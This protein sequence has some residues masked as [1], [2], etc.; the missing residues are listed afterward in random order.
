MYNVLFAVR[1]FSWQTP[2]SVP[3]QA[4]ILCIDPARVF[5][6]LSSF[7]ACGMYACMRFLVDADSF[8]REARDMLIR[9]AQRWNIPV[10]LVADRA[11]VPPGAVVDG[12][13]M[14]V[15]Q[16]GQ[17]SADKRIAEMATPDD[18]VFTRDIVF[19]EQ[20]INKKILAMNDRGSIFDSS[21]IRERLSLR[22][23]MAGM[24]DSG[25]VKAGANKYGKR[26]LQAFVQ[27]LDKVL[28]K[29]M[30]SGAG[31]GKREDLQHGK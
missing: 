19:A 17:D 30:K 4:N 15:V 2:F 25:L 18:L 6:H 27:S 9:Q 13:K 5:C 16:S 8:A 3:V 26:D 29:V 12:V 24:R 28:Q 10:I 23:F 22:D 21:T 1:K 20:I 7:G 11:L 14:L 31:A